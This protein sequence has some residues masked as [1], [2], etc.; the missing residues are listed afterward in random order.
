MILLTKGEIAVT[1]YKRER[2]NSV[3][4]ETNYDRK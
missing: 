4:E 2:L 1:K 3:V